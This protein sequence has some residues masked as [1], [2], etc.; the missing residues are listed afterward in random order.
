MTEIHLDQNYRYES[1]SRRSRADAVQLKHGDHRRFLRRHQQRAQ[2]TGAGVYRVPPRS[3]V[4]Q[5]GRNLWTQNS[6]G[7][8]VYFDVKAVSSS[9]C[10]PLCSQRTVR[11]D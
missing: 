3:D 2:G 1:R 8:K 6:A 11:R 4:L 9:R 5:D 10:L 7:A